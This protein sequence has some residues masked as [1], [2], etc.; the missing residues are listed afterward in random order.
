VRDRSRALVLCVANMN[1][2]RGIPVTLRAFAQMP[3]DCDFVIVGDGRNRDA[4][5][6]LCTDI[7]L[8]PA[9]VLI[10]GIPDDELDQLYENAD[11]YISMSDQESFGIS[12]MKAVAHGCR[13]VVSDIPPHREIVTTLGV[14]TEVLLPA[15]SGP[16]AVAAALSAQIAAAPVSRSTVVSVPTWTDSARLLVAAYRGMLGP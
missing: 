8:D 11:V 10:G 1:A 12:V 4:F 16:E 15:N 5:S 14:P 6:A 7:G 2:T 9:R 3:I 13:L